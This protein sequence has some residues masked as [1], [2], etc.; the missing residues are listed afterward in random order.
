[1][2]YVGIVMVTVGFLALM[3]NIVLGNPWIVPYLLWVA[4]GVVG[5]AIAVNYP[6]PKKWRWWHWL[7]I[8]GPMIA[9]AIVLLLPLLRERSI[10]RKCEA[11]QMTIMKICVGVECFMAD[12]GEFPPSGPKGKGTNGA[13]VYQNLVYYL[14]GPHCLGWGRAEGGQAPV[15]GTVPD[16]TFGPY[17]V[18]D[19]GVQQPFVICDAFEPGRPILYF[20]NAPGGS[21]L[22]HAEDNPLDA[23]GQTG[24]ASQEHFEMLVRPGGPTGDWVRKDYL[25]ISPGPDRL[26]GHEVQ[27]KVTLRMRPARRDE[28][29][30]ATCDDVTNFPHFPQHRQLRP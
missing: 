5:V 14:M 21:A 30:S 3:A 17:Y 15:A 24:F 4:L 27:D 2:R 10:N 16:R 9:V 26:Y 13:L 22:F 18:P 29:A 12:W 20:R 1:M 25:L 6:K 7:A 28:K 23:S 8:G 11:T 19:E